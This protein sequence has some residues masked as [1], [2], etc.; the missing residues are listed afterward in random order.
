MP[1]AP[2]IGAQVAD[3]FSGSAWGLGRQCPTSEALLG[4]LARLWRPRSAILGCGGGDQPVEQALR[5]RRHLVDRALR[6][7]LVGLGRLGESADLGPHELERGGTH[8]VVVR[9]RIEV[10]QGLDVPAL[11]LLLGR[12]VIRRRASAGAGTRAR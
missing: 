12:V 5:A 3:R 6:T 7:R 2:L 9:G 4:P 8:L 11:V 1:W 10:E